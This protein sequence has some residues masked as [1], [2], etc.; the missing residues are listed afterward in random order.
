VTWLVWFLFCFGLVALVVAESITA[1]PR[2]FLFNVLGP[3]WGGMLACA[4]CA[5]FWVGLAV[6]IPDLGILA[7]W[8]PLWAISSPIGVAVTGRLMGSI[9]LLGAV[10]LTQ[11][12]THTLIA[13]IG[14]EEAEKKRVAALHKGY[15][16]RWTKEDEDQ[17]GHA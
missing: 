12:A 13:E 15:E 4:P 14:A 8:L 7:Q 6:G 17:G 2:R 11:I 16:S 3:H 10:R 5:A 9:V 1:W